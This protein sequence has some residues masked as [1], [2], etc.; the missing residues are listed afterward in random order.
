M[1][2]IVDLQSGTWFGAEG[3][4]CID[5]TEEQMNEMDHWPDSTISDFAYLEW[6]YQGN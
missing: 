3:A 1:K 6:L 4:V 2:I 5:V